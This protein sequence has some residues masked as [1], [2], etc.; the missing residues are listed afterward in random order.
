MIITENIFSS[1]EIT[2]YLKVF[3]NELDEVIVTNN[4]LTGNLKYDLLESG[5]EE[6][7]NF[8]DFGIPGFKVKGR[9][10]YKMPHNYF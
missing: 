5:L 8:D 1:K 6:R 2:I 7:K 4:S 10:K 3:V 9:R